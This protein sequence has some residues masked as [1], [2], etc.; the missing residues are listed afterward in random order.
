MNTVLY[1]VP[2]GYIARNLLRTGVIERLLARDVR[3]VILTPAWNDPEFLQELS[4]DNRIVIDRLHKYNLPEN[5]DLFHRAFTSAC[6]RTWKARWAQAHQYLIGLNA[7]LHT[8]L[9]DRPYR[10]IFR[11][12]R[13]SLVVT[14]TTGNVAKSDLPVLWEARASRVKTLCLVHSWDNITGLFKG[15]MLARPDWLGTW[16]ELQKR[17]AVEVHFY[18]PDRVRVVGPPQ[19]DLYR[20]PD[21]FAPRDSFLRKIG[22]DPN[23]KV[24]TLAEATMHSA[25]NTY[26]LDIL[27]DAIREEKFVAPVQ[28]FCRM[29]PRR[30]PELSRKNY[31]KYL[32]NPLI[33]F[34][35]PDPHTRSLG[36][37]PT[38]ASMIYLANTLRHTDVLVNVASTVTIEASIL[39]VPVVNLGFSLTQPDRFRER[40]LDGAWRHH[41][42][43]ILERNG[44]YI[45]K[46]PGDLIKGINHYLMDPSL[47]REERRSVAR[48]LCYGCDGK[49][50][51]RIASL[52]L[53][54]LEQKRSQTPERV[55]LAPE[56][57]S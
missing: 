16:N 35:F 22:F 13:P 24:V 51:E 42:R 57:G 3:I 6:Y 17:E 19:F 28:L 25:E 38:R 33:T 52:I 26:I 10:H 32:N 8:V 18:D 49:S 36:W 47:H 41:Y 56:P 2:S 53:S 44:T 39:D 5:P 11:K 34:D 7:G 21:I 20:N 43:Y 54:L 31:E 50:A 29:H 15:M 45:A 12:Y 30:P 27:L 14:A 23:K 46:D 9:G 55:T 4:F 1:S 37:N 40:I 48:D